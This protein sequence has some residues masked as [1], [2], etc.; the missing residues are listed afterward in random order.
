MITIPYLT[1]DIH[2]GT[3][4]DIVTSLLYLNQSVMISSYMP[5]LPQ[6]YNLSFPKKKTDLFQSVKRKAVYRTIKTFN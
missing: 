6:Y 3:R 4:I 5:T 2:D 1:P